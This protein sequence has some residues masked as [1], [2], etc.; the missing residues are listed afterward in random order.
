M[1]YQQI[2]E[3]FAAFNRN[4]FSSLAYIMQTNLWIILSIAGA[5]AIVVM[6][7]REEVEDYVSEERNIT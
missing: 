7:I 2:L 1:S 5:A 6:N 4:A 3:S